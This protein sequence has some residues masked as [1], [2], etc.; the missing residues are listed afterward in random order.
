MLN[1]FQMLIHPSSVACDLLA[2]A[3]AKTSILI[4]LYNPWNNSTR[5]SQAPEDGSINIRNMFDIKR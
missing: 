1:M 5:K 3:N 4:E 2:Y